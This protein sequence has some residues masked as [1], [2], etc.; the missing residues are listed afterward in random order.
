MA[1][2]SAALEPGI[3]VCVDLCCL[4]DFQALIDTR[5]LDEHSIYYYV[6]RLLKHFSTSEIN[7]LIVP[8]P[9]L[10]L[11][12]IYDPLTP[13]DG[14]DRI[15]RELRRVYQEEG[16][17][18]AWLLKRYAIGHFETAAMRMDVLEWLKQWL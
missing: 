8:R 1:W 4:T 11:A 3:K 15:D 5:R 17:S 6:P 2:W 18:Q 13:A 9:H 10:S 7:S 16:A 12:G 14:L